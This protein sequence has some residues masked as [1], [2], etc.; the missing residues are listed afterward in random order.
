MK[1]MKEVS[2]I[3]VLYRLWVL[4]PEE[5]RSL[6]SGII[7]PNMSADEVLHCLGSQAITVR[8]MMIC[9]SMEAYVNA[10]NKSRKEFD[11][12]FELFDF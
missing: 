5:H 3:E 10:E 1:Y 8:Q 11:K 9:E 12:R 6:Y 2:G 4:F 7:M